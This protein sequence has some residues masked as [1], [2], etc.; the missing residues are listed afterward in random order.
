MSDLYCQARQTGRAGSR[1]W[2]C[3]TVGFS[4]RSPF[5]SV[6]GTVAWCSDYI[7]VRG[8]CGIVNLV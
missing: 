3:G 8:G 5:L 1:A 7:G 4:W 6:R 2:G